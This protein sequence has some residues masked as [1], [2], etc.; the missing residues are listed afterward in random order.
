MSRI[1]CFSSIVGV[2]NPDRWREEILPL[3]VILIRRIELCEI[4]YFRKIHLEV[5]KGLFEQVLKIALEM[6]AIKLGNPIRKRC[7]K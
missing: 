2:D 1:F 4:D 5:L 3:A 6:G 7:V